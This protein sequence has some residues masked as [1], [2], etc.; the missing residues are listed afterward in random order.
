[1]GTLAVNETLHMPP[2]VNY[3]CQQCGACCR[4]CDIAFSRDD[5]ERLSRYDWA[6]LVPDLPPG[7]WWRPNP[8]GDK[9][10]PYRMQSRPDHAC[11]FLDAENRCRMHGHTGELGKALGC[12]VY[13]FTFVAAPDEPVG[14]QYDCQ[15]GEER[16]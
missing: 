9:R 8:G 4:Q 15:E 10:E 3:D 16:M 14:G 5:H 13:P 6:A 2:F 12:S 7:E 11:V 1:M